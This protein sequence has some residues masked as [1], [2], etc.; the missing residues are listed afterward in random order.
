MARINLLIVLISCL[1]TLKIIP[2]FLI[3]I[4]VNVRLNCLLM[5]IYHTACSVST[6]HFTLACSF[7]PATEMSC[8]P[9]F[10]V[11]PA[12]DCHAFIISTSQLVNPSCN[13]YA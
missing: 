2:D 9:E 3:R 8:G 7:V 4:V 13:P 1:N 12:V 6:E 5:G 11:L 10:A